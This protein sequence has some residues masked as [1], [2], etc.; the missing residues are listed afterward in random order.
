MKNEIKAEL[1]S[2]LM[3]VYNSSDTIENSVESII[4]QDYENIEFLIVDDGST[5]DT[6]SKLLEFSKKQRKISL[7]KND[8]NI[9]L[10]KSLN[11]LIKNSKGNILARQDADDVSFPNRLSTQYHMLKKHNL[12]FCTTRAFKKDTNK[13]IPGYSYIIPQ[14]ILM[15]YKNPFIHGTLLIKKSTIEQVGCYDE[16]F[17]YSQ[18]Y[19]LMKDLINNN[20]SFK[21]LNECLYILNMNNNISTL[22]KDDQNYYANCVRQNITP[23]K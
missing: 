19:K 20:F 13:K 6:Y 23:S 1:I 2:V 21:L 7:F 15:K 17:Y 4:N 18:D 3:S 12:D 11:L 14:K 16:N 5:D 9:G 10:T 8:K 22:N